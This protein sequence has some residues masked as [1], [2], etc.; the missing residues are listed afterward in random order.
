MFGSASQL[1]V[2]AD[3]P[4]AERKPFSRPPGAKTPTKTIA[5]ADTDS[6]AGVKNNTR[7]SRWP[8]GFRLRK[9][10]SMKA[11]GIIT[12]NTTNSSMVVLRTAAQKFGSW[13]IFW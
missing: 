3:R 13:I 11:T 9:Y 1:V 2:A 12:T 8:G 5:L 10:P 4:A 6:N 7:R